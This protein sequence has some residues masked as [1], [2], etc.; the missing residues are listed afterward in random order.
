VQWQCGQEEDLIHDT[1]GKA[2]E[3]T[4]QFRLEE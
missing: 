4:L 2:R 3:G 1:L